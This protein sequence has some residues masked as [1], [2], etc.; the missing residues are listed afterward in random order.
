M[1]TF[2]QESLPKFKLYTDSSWHVWPGVI[3]GPFNNRAEL[4]LVTTWKN[5]LL[6]CNKEV[7]FCGGSGSL[8]GTRIDKAP[9]C[10]IVCLEYAK[11]IAEL[12][13]LS[14]EGLGKCEL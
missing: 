7:K 13:N 2:I 10:L 6:P 9:N 11:E 5:L 8:V 12:L 14:I 1:D 4:N 3:L